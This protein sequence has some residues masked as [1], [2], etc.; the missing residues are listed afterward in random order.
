LS[1]NA[2]DTGI[3]GVANDMLS[4]RYLNVDQKDEECSDLRPY[5]QITGLSYHVILVR[6]GDLPCQ[7]LYP[8]PLDLQELFLL[9]VST[10]RPKLVRTVHSVQVEAKRDP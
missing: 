7:R 1:L 4:H 3:F 10:K 6:D 5:A 9:C 2:A 8:S